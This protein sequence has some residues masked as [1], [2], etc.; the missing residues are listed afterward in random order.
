M[1]D[2]HAFH[3]RAAAGRR[4]ETIAVEQRGG[5]SG[6]REMRV[7]GVKCQAAIGQDVVESRHQ[8]LLGHDRQGA[9]VAELDGFGTQPL[10]AAR[11]KR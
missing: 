11:V 3:P 5:V 1:A 6:C 4:R 2:E 8:V 9:Q 7:D 10:Q